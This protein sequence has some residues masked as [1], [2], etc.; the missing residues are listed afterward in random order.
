VVFTKQVGFLFALFFFFYTWNLKTGLKNNLKMCYTEI[1]LKL[2]SV[3]KAAQLV[4]T[5]VI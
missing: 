3:S 5:G 1:Y 4:Y 2:K